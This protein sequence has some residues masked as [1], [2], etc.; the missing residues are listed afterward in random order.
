MALSHTFCF[1]KWT[2]EIKE[3]E[4]GWW[5]AELT[6]SNYLF[7]FFSDWHQPSTFPHSSRLSC[8]FHTWLHWRV[9]ELFILF[10]LGFSSF[11][12][13]WRPGLLQSTDTNSHPAFCSMRNPRSHPPHPPSSSSS[14]SDRMRL[15]HGHSVAQRRRCAVPSAGKGASWQRC[16]ARAR[17][18]TPQQN[19][20]AA[21][22]AGLPRTT[23]APP[24]RSQTRRISP[25]RMRGERPSRSGSL[26]VTL[27][28]AVA[29]TNAGFSVLVGRLLVLGGWL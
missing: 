26:K 2:G 18:A 21:S 8:G 20:P 28:A 9:T 13:L 6:D 15:T 27:A 25:H 3:L 7:F 10:A 24:A 19:E 17:N 16:G 22:L 4:L 11:R 5:W 12:Q 14:S 23:S 29:T 1:R